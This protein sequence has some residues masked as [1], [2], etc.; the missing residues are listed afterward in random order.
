MR[1]YKSSGFAAVQPAE[2]TP[3][4][5]AALQLPFSIQILFRDMRLYKSSSFAAVQPAEATPQKGQPYS[6]PFPYKS[7]SAT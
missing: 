6:Y 7:Y 1:L 5:R 2:A 4:K 3:Q